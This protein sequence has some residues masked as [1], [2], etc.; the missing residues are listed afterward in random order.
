MSITV[1]LLSFTKRENSTKV[2]TASDLAAGA[3]FSCTL[4]DNTTLFNPTFKLSIGSNPIGY[5]YCYVA[6]FGNR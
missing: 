2:P 4:L 5:N 3:S 6:D 1:N